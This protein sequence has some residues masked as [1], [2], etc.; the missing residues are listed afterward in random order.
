MTDRQTYRKK[1]RRTDRQKDRQ[2]CRQT[3][4][5]KER[6]SGR[7]I[8]GQTDRQMESRW[9]SDE[10][11]GP[12]PWPRWSLYCSISLL[13]PVEW[14]SSWYLLVLVGGWSALGE[15][16]EVFR[17]VSLDS[18]GW[19]PKWNL[20][21]LVDLRR[22]SICLIIHWRLVL[23]FCWKQRGKGI[24]EAGFSYIQ[25]EL[26]A[27]VVLRV[28]FFLE[29]INCRC[30]ADTKSRKWLTHDL[31]LPLRLMLTLRQ[32]TT[33]ITLSLAR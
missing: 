30:T 28:K 11:E 18:L 33:L 32:W 1:D 26:S 4:W 17:S 19:G 24:Y 31:I 10:D 15:T 3:E 8:E 21:E 13:Q 16:D 14:L 9:V 27:F 23:I 7:Q 12:A 5:Q 6:R 20:L 25:S 29:G 22:L 2:K